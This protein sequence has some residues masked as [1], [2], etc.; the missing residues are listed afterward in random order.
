[1]GQNR[2]WHAL[3]GLLLAASSTL[4]ST[5]VW[6]TRASSGDAVCKIPFTL[7]T[8]LSADAI[9]VI[10]LGRVI[11]DRSHPDRRQ[12]F[13]LARLISTLES[14]D[15]SSGNGERL[16]CLGTHENERQIEWLF[17]LEQIERVEALDGE[18]LLTAL[19]SRH[20]VITSA[21]DDRQ[22]DDTLAPVI[23]ELPPRTEWRVGPDRK[24]IEAS[25]RYRRT[26][27][28]SSNCPASTG[29]SQRLDVSISA[30]AVGQRIHLE[31]SH[32]VNGSLSERVLWQLDPL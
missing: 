31:Q 15:A 18:V 16:R 22:V 25:S 5:T 19:E 23:M 11:A 4:P 24:S 9:G 6:A 30:R 3:A 14:L 21:V 10:E 26:G 8:S 29:C 20:T 2:Q 13:R 27:S 17:D 7:A 12:A 32:Y 1:M 28:R